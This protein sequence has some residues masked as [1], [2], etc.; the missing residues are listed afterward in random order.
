MTRRRLLPKW[1]PVGVTLLALSVTLGVG[2]SSAHDPST[3]GGL[4]RSRNAGTT[5]ASANP[6]RII[7]AA[8]SLAISPTDPNHLLLATE[9][10]LMRSSNGGRDWMLESL[11]DKGAA[12][13]VV[14]DADGRRALV[15]TASDLFRTEDGNPWR[16]LAPPPGTT[17]AR[18]M[19][20]GGA[21]GRVYLAG[22]KRFAQSDD[23]GTTWVTAADG[24]PPGPV[25]ALAVQP[26]PAETVY[27][28]VDGRIWARTDGSPTWH[29][30]MGGETTVQV[31]ALALDPS[32]AARI[33]A[34]G[35]GQ[36]FRS[37][38]S[39]GRW[40]A[41]G[42]PLQTGGTAVHSIAASGTLLLVSTDQGL[43]R[44][45]DAGNTWQLVTDNLPGHLDAGPLVRDPANPATLYAGFT[46]T[47]YAELW[48]A[49]IESRAR[50]EQLDP[51]T[52]WFWIAVLIGVLAAAVGVGWLAGRAHRPASPPVSP[53]RSIS[54][55]L[56]MD[57]ARPLRE[58]LVQFFVIG[59]ALFLLNHWLGSGGNPA[60][61]RIE[62]SSAQAAR[63][64]Q[65]FSEQRGRPPTASE[66]K[67]VIDEYVREEILVREALEMGLDRGDVVVRRRLAQKMAALAGD[68][69]GSGDPTEEELRTF[70]DFH[71]DRYRG[72]V[73]V[74]FTQLYFNGERRGASAE[75]EARATLERLQAAQRLPQSV[76]ERGDAFTPQL[77]DG[78]HSQAELAE[79]FGQGFAEA[80]LRLPTGVWEGPI[81]S[82]F[83]YHLVRVDERSVQP[84]PELAA[85]RDRVI[86]DWRGGR[87]AET[88]A[89]GLARLRTRYEVVIT[90][91]RASSGA[92][93][94]AG[95][96]R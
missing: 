87:R 46:L 92:G 42:Q 33:W 61:R 51:R 73:R 60:G 28:V 89:A 2:A 38:D 10:G 9:S 86:A 80:V 19:V 43:Y 83:G 45:A 4:F 14:F 72:P 82:K 40:Q 94:E 48:R 54:R 16:S 1:V 76:P 70:F 27:A 62:V 44:S 84:V 26:G 41:V 37:D 58:P 81:R 96:S 53:P 7:G 66:A 22:W 29:S 69:E 25:I 23:W 55:A 77:G 59:A 18:A 20:R 12:F 74:R 49:A 90:T 88:D 30:R 8:I 65:A 5:W 15:S 71:A 78:L 75:T 24:L 34:V 39:G 32:G 3:S 68:L 56:R 21:P 47:P 31:E 91:P 95:R 13:A 85:V 6:E 50:L 63:L 17:P 93:A 64:I 57:L 36:V 79:L 67:T 52:F 35:A 11:K